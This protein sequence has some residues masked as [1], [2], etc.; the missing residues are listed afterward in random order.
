[1]ITANI[2]CLYDTGRLPLKIGSS[3]HGF[4]ADQWRVWTTVYSPIA[5]KKTLPVNHLRVW[6]L[7][8]RACSMLCKRLIKKS[9]IENACV[10][11]K[12]FCLK[13]LEVYGHRH[14]SPNMH[15][16]THLLECCNDYGSVYGFWCF[17]FERYNGI[18]RSYQTKDALK[19]N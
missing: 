5:L 15:M 7:F 1:M 4:T 18:L 6:L 10:Y 14:F 12:Q 9:E 17:A 2:N 19:H 8:V 16:H 3:F 11:L 13:C